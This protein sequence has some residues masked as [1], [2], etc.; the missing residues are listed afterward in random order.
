[1]AKPVLNTE[2]VLEVPLQISDGGGGFRTVWSPVGTLWADVTARSAR[3]S[4]VAAR[5][6][7]EVTHRIVIRAAP[8]GSPRRPTPDC[9]FRA[10]G[11]VFAIRGV[12]PLDGRGQY[13][14]CWAEEGLFA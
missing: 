9:R 10:G 5:S 1:M 3:E 12:A 2:L 6:L 11:R 7:S 13:L 4:A 14:T 8:E